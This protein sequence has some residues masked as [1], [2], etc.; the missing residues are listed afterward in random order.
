MAPRGKSFGIA[1]RFVLP[2][3][4]GEFASIEKV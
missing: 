1:V 2:N 4:L 3:E